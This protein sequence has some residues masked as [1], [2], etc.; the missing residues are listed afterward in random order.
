VLVEADF[1]LLLHFICEKIAS[2]L[3]PRLN[4]LRILFLGLVSLVTMGGV[5]SVTPAHGDNASTAS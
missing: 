1:Q 4:I 3:C 2:A 5:W